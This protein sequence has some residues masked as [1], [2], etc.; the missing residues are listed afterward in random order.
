M[1]AFYSTMFLE[2]T[3]LLS[4][5]IALKTGST[6]WYQNL[7]VMLVWGGFALGI[8]FMILYYKFFHI[9]HL[10]NTLLA[11]HYDPVEY[12]AN[13]CPEHGNQQYN[14]NVHSNGRLNGLSKAM[15][16][17]KMPI[18]LMNSTPNGVITGIPGV[19]NCRLN[20][21]L[22]RKKK[23]PS[24]F[25]PPPHPTI[26]APNTLNT[27]TS[28]ISSPSSNNVGSLQSNKSVTK[29]IKAPPVPSP[30]AFW[31]KSELANGFLHSQPISP[32]IT[33]SPLTLPAKHPFSSTIA[34]SPVSNFSDLHHLSNKLIIPPSSPTSVSNEL[35]NNSVSRVNIQQKLQEKK[36]QQFM[37]LKKIE[38]EIKQGK[39]KPHLLDRIESSPPLL[40]QA[41]APQAKKQPWIAN[42]ANAPFVPLGNRG[43]HHYYYHPVYRRI[44]LRSQ[45]PEVLLAPHYLDNSRVYYDYPS[46]VLPP[47][48]SR[49]LKVP[50][51]GSAEEEE[52]EDNN[53]KV[54]TNPSAIEQRNAKNVMN[55][56]LKS[57]NQ[58]NRFPSDIDSQV[59]L[60]RSYTLPRE[61]QYYRGN[62][63]VNT[64]NAA[65]NGIGSVGGVCK[66][67]TRKPLPNEHFHANVESNSSNDG[68][69]DSDINQ[70]DYDISP[71]PKIIRGPV[72]N[73]RA[74][75]VPIRPR[76]YH[77]HSRIK[78]HE[79][80]L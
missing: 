55:R 72:N 11:T 2:N 60:P 47:I 64:A 69:V 25:I 13:H 6:P 22:K 70:D 14:D 35:K 58:V 27:I 3:L 21:A 54:G 10:K 44:K 40:H 80:P 51:E 66:P 7:S 73:V 33:S 19:F 68:D 43:I 4:I 45:T 63:S 53:Y 77:H 29:T 23:K 65:I 24:S 36:Q 8:L 42:S 62:G 31:K 16:E 71:V 37:Q 78:R 34:P 18:S 76:D 32:T 9:R 49:P 61:F 79:T 75:A 38:E 74:P 39:L 20:P 50:L 28:T 59:S 5:C 52:E 48:Q 12:A 1:I 57:Y 17:R 46:C 56:D 15:C 67:R 30:T 41:I 26:S